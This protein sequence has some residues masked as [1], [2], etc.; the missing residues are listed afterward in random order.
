MAP[1]LRSL[2]E[3]DTAAERAL[4]FFAGF[5][6]VKALAF[7]VTATNIGGVGY[8]IYYYWEQLLATP[9]YLLPFVPDSP[10]GPFLMVIIFALWWFKG[11]RRSPT[12]EVLAFCFLIKFGVWTLVAFALFWD[13]FFAPAAASLSGTLL[14]L[15]FM[16]AM[17]AAMLLKGMRLPSLPLGAFAL[18]W[19]LLGDYCDYNLGAH[20]RLPPGTHEVG[21]IPFMTVALTFICFFVAVGW[22]RHVAAPAPAGPA[23]AAHDEGPPG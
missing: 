16:E 2:L 1:G 10:S 11:Q 20:P 14:I 22:C 12:L 3:G 18:G 19:M 6:E 15:H 4:N 8:G 5:R 9:W 13:V 17:S 21:W 7:I 23:R